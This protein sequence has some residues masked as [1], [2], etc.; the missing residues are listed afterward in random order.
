VPVS[1]ALLRPLHADIRPRVGE[2]VAASL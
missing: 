2:A 1:R